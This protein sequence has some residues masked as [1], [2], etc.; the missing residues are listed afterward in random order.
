MNCALPTETENMSY[1]IEYIGASW[2]SP[3]KLVK[4]VAIAL[5]HKF[6][7]PITVLDYD[8]LEDI[9]KDSVKKLPTIRIVSSSAETLHEI[10]T[11]HADTLDIWLRAHVRVNGDEDF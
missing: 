9:H 2:C 7:V 5:A 8:E 4:P 6:A 3:C 1:R 10:T 11:N